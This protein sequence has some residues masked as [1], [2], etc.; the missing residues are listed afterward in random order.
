MHYVRT[1]ISTAHI[2]L[3]QSAYIVTYLGSRKVIPRL[4][5][6]PERSSSG[7]LLGLRA[8]FANLF[9]GILFTIGFT[10]MPILPPPPLG[11]PAMLNVAT[12]SQ[13]LCFYHTNSLL[14]SEVRSRRDL[15]SSSHL[16]RIQPYSSEKKESDTTTFCRKIEQVPGN[17][18]T[19]SCLLK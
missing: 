10:T 1:T 14:R 3:Q 8:F 17:E 5:P 13:Q 6:D 19:T 4:R 2:I 12:T 7:L 18:A 11:F 9:L 15:V 16:H